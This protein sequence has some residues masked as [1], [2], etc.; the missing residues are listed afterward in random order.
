MGRVAG[1]LPFAE[2]EGVVPYN[3]GNFNVWHGPA[4]GRRF[5]AFLSFAPGIPKE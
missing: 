2:G 5:D 1:Q 4:S 3:G